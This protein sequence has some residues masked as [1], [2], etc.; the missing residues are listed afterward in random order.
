[1]ALV[2][3]IDNVVSINE[4]LQ[5]P[6]PSIVRE[7]ERERHAEEKKEGNIREKKERKRGKEKKNDGRA[8]C[9]TSETV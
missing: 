3:P 1:M 5:T 2:L 7:R 9:P 6:L 4:M 8:L